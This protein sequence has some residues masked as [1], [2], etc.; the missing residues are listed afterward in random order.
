MALIKLDGQQFTLPDQIA[1]DDQLL[2]QAL[3][4][5]APEIGQPKI[6]RETQEGQLVVTV[7]KQAGPKGGG[8]PPPTGA[9]GTHSLPPA[10][11]RV[12]GGTQARAALD[13]GTVE[14]YRAAMADGATFPPVIVFY[15]G[16]DHWLADG[17]HRRAAALTAGLKQLAV[18]IRIGTQRDAQLYAAGANASHGLR[19][20][21]ADKRRAVE[22]L[23]R[24]AEWGQWSDH[25]IARRTATTHP[26]VAKIRAEL[27]A[28]GNGYQMPEQ[29]V[30]QR[31]DQTY[32]LTPAPARP[33]PAPGQHATPAEADPGFD[34]TP[35]VDPVG[36]PAPPPAPA[37][38]P[39][40]PV[41]APLPVPGQHAPAPAIPIPVPVPVPVPVVPPAWT[42][43][44]V[45]ISI[46]LLPAQ[47]DP[48]ARAALI[49]VYNE[50]MKD[51][52]SQLVA[53]DDLRPLPPV[54]LELLTE[55]EGLL[56]ERQATVA[57]V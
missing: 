31:G 21:N 25:E 47:G 45:A 51:L 34:F 14:E 15:D 36:D 19:R 43:C 3:R 46:Q 12:N 33:I 57:A 49:T 5:V 53:E 17:F 32:T 4:A 6:G 44:T 7:V 52:R 50:A 39:P 42:A 16:T 20:T 11:I 27:A 29:R 8:S 2:V 10:T 24:D 18:E 22:L 40:A 54:L 38:S 55:L 56:A 37:V 1:E 23:L 35:P 9:D 26:F 13:P 30:V 28:S 48:P 41:A